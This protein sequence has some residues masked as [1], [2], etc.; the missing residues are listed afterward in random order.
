MV[1]LSPVG[2]WAIAA[3]LVAA[4]PV[5]ACLVGLCGV[6]PAAPAAEAALMPL[7]AASAAPT[8]RPLREN[9]PPPPMDATEPLSFSGYPDAPAFTV[10][11][12]QPLLALYPCSQCHKLMPVNTQPRKLVSA[13]HQAALDHGKGRMW[14]LDC[15]QGNDRDLLHSTRNTQFGFNE[16]YQLCGQ[17]HS[18]RQRDWYFGAHGKRVAGW[19]GER[20]LYACTHCHD[21]HNPVLQPR[22][23]S[24][25][26]PVRAGLTPMARVA[27]D[28]PLM[29]HSL[30]KDTGH[31]R[32][33]KP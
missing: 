17:C 2:R 13:P 28:L 25:P 20:Q 21:P 33:E 10:V 30:K 16:S 27:D 19:N 1:V 32:P 29:W 26:P 5:A 15:H 14:C 7:P 9:Q 24:K 31:D 3:W 4:W 12:R 18:A 6:A 23:P 22:A 11:P 8:H